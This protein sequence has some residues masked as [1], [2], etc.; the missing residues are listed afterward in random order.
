MKSEQEHSNQQTE[1]VHDKQ[2]MFTDSHTQQNNVLLSMY[3]NR[4]H[5]HKPN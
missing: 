5:T 1:G 4:A 2:H 3:Y